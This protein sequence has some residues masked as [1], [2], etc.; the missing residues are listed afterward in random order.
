MRNFMDNKILGRCLK[1][2]KREVGNVL[3][4]QRA[5]PQVPSALVDFTAGFEMDPGVPLPLLP[6][7]NSL[8]YTQSLYLHLIYF[9]HLYICI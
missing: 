9:H 5:A 4:S 2:K 1:V 3:L 8:F 7:T 6:P